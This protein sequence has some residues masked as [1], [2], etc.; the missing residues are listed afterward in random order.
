MLS[1]PPEKLKKMFI[2]EGLIKS[3]EFDRLALEA[4]RKQQN[5]VDVLISR[6][7]IT[8]DYFYELLAKLLAVERIEL[9]NR[10]IPQE[11]LGLLT[12]ETAQN[13][14]ILIFNKEADGV[15]DVAME[16]PT[17]LNLVEFLERRLQAKIKP[18]L[19][20]DD[21]LTWGFSLYEAQLVKDFQ[22]IIEEKIGASL[23]LLQGGEENLSKIAGELPIVSIAENIL[24][25]AASLHASDIH[26]EIVEE[27]LLVR[28]RV[29]GI[30][31]EIA[32]IPKEIQPALVA[33]LKLLAG[34]RIDEHSRP[35]D[36]RLRFQSGRQQIDIRM[37]VMPTFYGEKIVMRLL[38]ATQKPISFSEIGM[39]EDTIK[40]VGEDIK[41]TFGMLLVCGPTGSGKTTTLYSVLNILNKPEVN[42]VTVED[43]IEYNIR[44]VNQTQ[45][46]PAANIT[47]ANGLRA[48]LRQDPNVIM[49]G[50]IRDSE[51]AEIAVHA[52]LT[53]HLVLSS[54]HTN[55]APTAIP[56]LI[57][58]G[59]PPFLAAAVLNLVV[60]QRL[61]RRIHQD[62]VESYTPDE[63][64]LK[65]IQRQ[66]TELGLSLKEIRLPK[67]FY[68]G[69]G[70]AGCNFSGYFGRLAI[71]EALNF[72]DE[73]RKLIIAPSFSLDELKSLAH[74]QGMVS[75]FEDGL[76]KI[77]LGMTTI[78]EVLRAIRE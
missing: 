77:E 68:R 28:F 69:K 24:T 57:D 19:A 62:C 73:I 40:I 75:M 14:H 18:F 70:C 11:I 30:L 26:L 53:G 55:D 78:E 38:S 13:R 33:R 42:I 3:E 66:L 47:F 67:I 54:L 7:F 65:F 64:V 56:R 9:K 29:D 76:R 71:F 36:G 22:K 49:I 4:K 41:K 8:T 35:Q 48:I 20:S 34:L 17:D 74:Q 60:A 37:S 6:G 72:T 31:Q 44:Y 52:A 1:L 32:R 21:D 50:E 23:N 39:L 25:Y 46:N 45:V 51:T 10:K 16:D 5:I 43:P 63:T 61:T 27:C 59:I 12:R 58:M 15:L 2:D